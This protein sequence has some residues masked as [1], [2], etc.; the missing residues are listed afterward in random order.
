PDPRR[1]GHRGHHQQGREEPGPGHGRQ[2]ELGAADP[3]DPEV[4]AE[5]VAGAPEGGCLPLPYGAYPA[6]RVRDALA[7]MREDRH[8]GEIVLLFDP[9]D[10]PPTPFTL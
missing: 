7:A 9:L 1:T 6:A 2:V 10:D 5:V 3:A 8:L 4:F